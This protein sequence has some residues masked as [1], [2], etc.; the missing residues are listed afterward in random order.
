MN[1]ETQESAHSQIHFLRAKLSY[2][3]TCSNMLLN[4]KGAFAAYRSW[5]NPSPE[6]YWVELWVLQG[7]FLPARLLCPTLLNLLIFFQSLEHLIGASWSRVVPDHSFMVPCESRTS[8]H[9]PGFPQKWTLWGRIEWTSHSP[10][11]M[12]PWGNRLT[13]PVAAES[14]GCHAPG[15]QPHFTS[16]FIQ[17]GMLLTVI[18]VFN[19][20]LQLGPRRWSGVLGPLISP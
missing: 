8:T 10:E 6:K 20:L 18:V 9:Y 4:L 11:R 17:L 13:G 14:R 12:Q 16:Q 3:N 15:P 7:K 2:L 5:V 19:Q 1:H